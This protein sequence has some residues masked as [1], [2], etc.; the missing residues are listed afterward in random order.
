MSSNLREPQPWDEILAYYHNLIFE[1]FHKMPLYNL[2]LYIMESNVSDK[3][4]GVI[5][6]RQLIIG[7]ERPLNI[8]ND[9]LHLEYKPGIKSFRFRYY[10]DT[11]ELPRLD[12]TY[13]EDLVRSKLNF[14]TGMAWGI[15]LEIHN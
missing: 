13:H 7:I 1:G 15:N 6:D 10:R 14:V 11:H 5:N 4:L 3:L 2:V 8:R 12:K 9:V